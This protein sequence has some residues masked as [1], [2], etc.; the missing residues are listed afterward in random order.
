M[1]ARDAERAR[2]R[3]APQFDRLEGR[4]LLTFTLV[5]SANLL[6][7][8]AVA[9][10]QNRL[11]VQ[12]A[13]EG[14]AAPPATNP[15][16]SPLTTTPATTG[17]LTPHEAVR[18]SYVG[19]FKG[20]YQVGPGRT[21]TQSFQITS[22]GYGGSNQ[23]YHLWSNLRLTVPTDPTQPVTGVAYIISWNVGTTG[24]QL[25]LDLTGDPTSDVNGVPTRYTWT[26]DPA[27]A[28]I[29]TSGNTGYGTGTGTLDVQ[30]F[31]PGKGKG[32]V[33]EQGQLQYSINGLIDTGGGVFN[34]LGVLGN[35][36][37]N[38]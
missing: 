36:P 12:A 35:I 19:R 15:A 23:S 33:I 8:G 14:A 38:P 18:Q 9:A 31:R 25:I 10:I 29:Y 5:H 37:K 16:E 30:F 6:G 20:S 27:S 13:A 26:V 21:S 11:A 4:E 28:G 32:A 34:D 1:N 2:R 7:P 22:L 17:T 3:R 24:T